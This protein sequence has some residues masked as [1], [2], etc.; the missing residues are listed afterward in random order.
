MLILINDRIL[1]QV[2]NLLMNKCVNDGCVDGWMMD[3]Q[4]AG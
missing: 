1:S 2:L 3:G 4:M